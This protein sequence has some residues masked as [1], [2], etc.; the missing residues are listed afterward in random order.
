VAGGER[1]AGNVPASAPFVLPWEQFQQK[2]EAVSHS[3]LRKN[4]GWSASA[5]R[6]KA[7]M[8]YVF[9]NFPAA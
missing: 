9:R 5:I 7:E 8:L 4:K 2:C 3:E 1:G 6:G